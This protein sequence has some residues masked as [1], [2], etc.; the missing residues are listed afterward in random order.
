MAERSGEGEAVL[1]PGKIR[2]VIT[3]LEM[4]EPPADPPPAAPKWDLTLRR[5]ERP[6]VAF[7]RDL[8][9]R[10]GKPWLW[11]DRRKLNDEELAAIITDPAVEVHVLY[12]GD[13]FVGYVE[14]DRRSPP[15]IEIA[16][17]GIVP[18]MI[19]RGVG[20][21]LLRQAVDMA[22]GYG[23]LRVWLHTCTLDHPKA[24]EF[25]QKAGFRAYKTEVEILDDP[26]LTGLV[27]RD[28]APHIPIADR[29]VDS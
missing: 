22:F 27:P 2:S 18:E 14:L 5:I 13:R 11:I 24:A 15:D 17:F 28:S 19:G 16:Y 29:A 4:A 23:A 7:Y 9:D 26:R 25:Y 1:P 12:E 8:Y 6:A 21:Y 20:A 10:V 3:Y